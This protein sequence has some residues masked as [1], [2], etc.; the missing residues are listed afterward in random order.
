MVHRADSDFTIKS[1][2]NLKAVSEQSLRS[3][4]VNGES[5]GNITCVKT[6]ETCSNEIKQKDK[7]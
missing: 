1:R 2:L 6:T 7:C 4:R 5:V 3:K